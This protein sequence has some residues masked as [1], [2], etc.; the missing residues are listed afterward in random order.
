AEAGVGLR[1][2]VYAAVSGPH[3]ETP[4]ELRMLRTM[5]ADLVGMS[6]VPE[7][8]VAAHGGLRVLGL[9]VVTDLA[10]PEAPSSLSHADVVAAGAAAAP[11]LDAILRGV[12]R[13]EN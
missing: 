8:I 6:T 12:L 10:F 9:S 5:G 2:G 13:R 3:Y 4:A 1:R 7:A 11:A